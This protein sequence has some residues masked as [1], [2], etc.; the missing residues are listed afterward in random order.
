[1]P[2]W[3]DCEGCSTNQP[4]YLPVYPPLWDSGITPPA[5]PAATVTG[6]VPSSAS[7]GSIDLYLEVMGTGFS[8]SSRIF[9]DGVAATTQYLGPNRLRT[10]LPASQETA[11]RAVVVTVQNGPTAATGS[12]TFNYTD[13]PVIV[14]EPHITGVTPNRMETDDPDTVVHIT[15]TDFI[16]TTEVYV[17]GTPVETTHVSDTELTYVARGDAVGAHVV[18]VGAATAKSGG[19]VF[20]VTQPA[21]TLTSLSPPDTSVGAPILVTITGTGFSPTTTVTAS[22]EPVAVTYVSSTEL[23]YTVPA[24][25][26][27]TFE[28]EAQNETER[29]NILMFTTTAAAP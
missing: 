16:D 7:W 2:I 18:T 27:G 6:I 15:G 4:T 14:V 3:I 28:I 22:Q 25:N 19:A 29:S 9:L 23:T 13:P 1:M 17:D 26:A 12:K 24:V 8:S 10:L 5:A 20:M 21:L 11:A